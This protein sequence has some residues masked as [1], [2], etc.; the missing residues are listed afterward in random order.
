MGSA[1]NYLPLQSG[2]IYGPVQSRR[3]GSSLG[4]NLLPAH[5]KICS[6]NCVYC[7]YGPARAHDLSLLQNERAELPRPADVEAALR[8]A[9]RIHRDINYITF[10]GNGEATLHPEFPEIVDVIIKVRDELRL[11][12][13]TAI[14]TNSTGIV[15]PDV[16]KSLLRLD[17]PFMKLDVGSQSLLTRLNRAHPDIEFHRLVQELTRLDH[18]HLVIQAIFF[19][20]D[21]T[22][23]DDRNVELWA[24]I[25]RQIN[26]REVHI[27]TTDR[28]VA[29]ANVHPVAESILDGIATKAQQ[30]SGVTI[31]VF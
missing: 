14:L 20:G 24:D 23:I 30:I 21:P 5:A 11:R 31:R 4:I 9:L 13:R 29:K 19:S 26:P 7:Q 6:F 22:N 2:I 25:L 27:Y 1:D 28:P 8:G 15:I 18:Q 3:L 12:A 16:R 17:N 10:S